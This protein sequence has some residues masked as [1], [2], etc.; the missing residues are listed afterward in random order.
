MH[1]VETTYD[2]NFCFVSLQYETIYIAV[3]LRSSL[4]RF[5]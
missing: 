2:A 3:N 4:L 5:E 1:I